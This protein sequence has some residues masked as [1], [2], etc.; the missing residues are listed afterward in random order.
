M[1][2][3]PFLSH[4][5]LDVSLHQYLALSRH[6]ILFVY[7]PYSD[8]TLCFPLLWL[9][10]MFLLLFFF[11]FHFL[12][13]SVVARGKLTSPR[14][15]SELGRWSCL[16]PPRVYCEYSV[17]WVKEMFSAS[18]ISSGKV[19]I[20]LRMPDRPQTIEGKSQNAFL[21]LRCQLHNKVKSLF[22]LYFPQSLGTECFHRLIWC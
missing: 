12:Q 5:L 16:C 4:S 7:H 22:L 21:D 13:L 14:I 8:F 6:C 20:H 18:S 11:C 3:G 9:Y 1:K 10:L 15:Y 2:A 19:G 17:S